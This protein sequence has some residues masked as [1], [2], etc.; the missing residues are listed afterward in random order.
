[1]GINFTYYL[2]DIWIGYSNPPQGLIRKEGV[3][4]IPEMFTTLFHFTRPR[5][6][7][8]HKRV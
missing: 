7:R 8:M 5:H 4:E 2:A 3:V 6:L 1:M